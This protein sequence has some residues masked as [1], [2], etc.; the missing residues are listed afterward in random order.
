MF[1]EKSGVRSL[2]LVLGIFCSTWSRAQ[3]A[4][5]RK[6]TLEARRDGLPSARAAVAIHTALDK[7]ILEPSPCLEPLP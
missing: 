3:T 2:V 7:Q 4:K 6:V 5:I 1:Q